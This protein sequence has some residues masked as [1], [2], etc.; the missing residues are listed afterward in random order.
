MEQVKKQRPDE[1]PPALATDGKGAYREA[2]LRTWGKVPQS[3]G[4][5]KPP[6]LPQP[7]KDWHYLQ[8]VKKRKGGRGVECAHE[9]R[10][11]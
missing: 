9:G 11:R 6:T 10:L 5:G 4:R 8:V 7:D 2:M 1:K 3:R